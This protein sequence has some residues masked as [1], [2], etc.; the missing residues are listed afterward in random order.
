MTLA[1]VLIYRG[2]LQ[3]FFRAASIAMAPA[4]LLAFS[5]EITTASPYELRPSGRFAHNVDAICADAEPWFEVLEAQATALRQEAN[6]PVAGA[7]FLLR[8]T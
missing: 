7:L 6:E 4:G 8:R 2:P 3:A 5:V 1:D